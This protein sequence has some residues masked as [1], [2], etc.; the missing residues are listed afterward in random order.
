MPNF[1]VQEIC[2]QIQPG[3]A[4]KVW[5]EWLGFPAMRMVNG[6]F[7]LSQKPGLGFELTEA[8]AGEVS[9]RRHASHGARVSRRRIRRRVVAAGFGLISLSP[10]GI[11]IPSSTWKRNPC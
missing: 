10:T 3:A 9:V 8:S 7:P 11:R 2:G 4:D 5:E 6:R 1:L